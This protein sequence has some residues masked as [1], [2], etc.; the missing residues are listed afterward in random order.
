MKT[1]EGHKIEPE[2]KNAHRKVLNS[3]PVLATNS[4]LRPRRQI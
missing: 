2:L 3:C 4:V 1:E